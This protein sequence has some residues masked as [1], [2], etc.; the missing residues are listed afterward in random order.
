[1]SVPTLQKLIKTLICERHNVVQTSLFRIK[2]QDYETLQDDKTE[3]EMLMPHKEKQNITKKK[4]T[5]Q[6]FDLLIV[7]HHCHY[8]HNCYIGAS[9]MKSWFR[10]G[11]HA[12]RHNKC[13]P[14]LDCNPAG[15]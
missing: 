8:E 6:M 11:P 3:N 12:C 2:G 9:C 13:F 15:H 1:M 7:G 14:Q 4:K 10:L 5:S